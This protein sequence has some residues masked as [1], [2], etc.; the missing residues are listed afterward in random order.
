MQRLWNFFIFFQMQTEVTIK[1]TKSVLSIIHLP[2]KKGRTKWQ[3]ENLGSK[4]QIFYDFCLKCLKFIYWNVSMKIYDK[5]KKLDWC[6]EIPN[7]LILADNCS[8][9]SIEASILE[10][11]CPWPPIQGLFTNYVIRSRWVG[12]WWN[13]TNYNFR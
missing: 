13:V 4:I 2:V 5:L 6:G 12:G 10:N 7:I 8:R 11:P 1:A 3:A 9:W